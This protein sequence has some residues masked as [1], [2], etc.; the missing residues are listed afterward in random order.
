MVYNLYN[1]VIRGIIMKRSSLAAYYFYFF[2]SMPKEVIR[3]A[4]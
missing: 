3:A 1:T 2:W 4:R